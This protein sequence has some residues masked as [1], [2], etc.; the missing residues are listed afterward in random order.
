VPVEKAKLLPTHGRLRRQ[1]APVVA[2]VSPK[3]L[4]RATNR[5]EIGS[6]ALSGH[7]P[8][9]FDLV[10]L[11]RPILLRVL[12]AVPAVQSAAFERIDVAECA[13]VGKVELDDI[14]AVVDWCARV[15]TQERFFMEAHER[16]RRRRGIDVRTGHGGGGGRG[17]AGRRYDWNGFGRR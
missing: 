9:T 12:R 10:A 11:P 3:S 14:V 4:V 2:R 5:V 13:S 1:D 16:T 17:R 6:D 7:I 15:W 8:R